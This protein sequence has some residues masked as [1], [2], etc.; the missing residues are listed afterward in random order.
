MSG[1]DLSRFAD[2]ARKPEHGTENKIIDMEMTIEVVQKYDDI[3]T[4]I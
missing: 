4:P 1:H 2:D 3:P